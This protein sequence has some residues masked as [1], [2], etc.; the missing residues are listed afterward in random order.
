MAFPNSPCKQCP[1]GPHSPPGLCLAI[2]LEHERF[3]ELVRLEAEGLID[4]QY[5]AFLEAVAEWP[6]MPPDR[7]G[8]QEP[9]SF[10]AD[11]LARNAG[12]EGCGCG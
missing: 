6:P 1:R 12:P 8:R 11:L 9:P 4:T 5:T 7:P 10:H 3:C 2:R